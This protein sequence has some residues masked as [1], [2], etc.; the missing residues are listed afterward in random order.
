MEPLERLSS[1]LARLALFGLALL[2]PGCVLTESFVNFTSDK[3][4]GDVAKVM[5]IWKPAVVS[6]PDPVHGGE[7][8]NGLAGRVYLF[9]PDMSVPLVGDGTIVVD[10]YSDMPG[11]GKAPLEEWRFEKDSLKQLLKRD[12]AGW[13]YTLF[14]PWGTYRPDITR[15]HLRLRYERPKCLPIYANS[16]PMALQK[17]GDGIVRTTSSQRV[18][19]PTNGKLP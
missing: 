18:I 4:S 10:L 3:P 17:P 19:V 8:L 1:K 11:A 6:T 13:G 2:L 5:A 12:A 9:G 7:P 14:L 16:E 15:V